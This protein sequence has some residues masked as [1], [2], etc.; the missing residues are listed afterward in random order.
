[1]QRLCA[2]QANPCKPKYIQIHHRPQTTLTRTA[3]CRNSTAMS[4]PNVSPASLQAAHKQWLEQP[5]CCLAKKDSLS[6]TRHVVVSFL[7]SDARGTT[8][9]ARHGRCNKLQCA[10]KAS[11]LTEAHTHKSGAPGKPVDETAGAK[12]GHDDEEDGGKDACPRTP[13]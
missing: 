4:I 5:H 3:C 10:C 9:Q 12:Q 1:M 8:C 7:F 11:S 6:G 13:G 2:L